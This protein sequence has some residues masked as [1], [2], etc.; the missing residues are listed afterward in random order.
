MTYPSLIS[1]PLDSS[2][3]AIMCGGGGG[4]I[5]YATN[6]GGFDASFCKEAGA[7][8]EAENDCTVES[9]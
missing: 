3:I 5:C 4:G 8:C 2:E 7:E 6:V 9:A 1:L